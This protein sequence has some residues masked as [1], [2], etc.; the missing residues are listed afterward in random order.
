MN[1][2]E[3]YIAPKDSIF[4]E[5]KEKSIEIWKTYSDEFGYSSSKINR[6]KDVLNIRDN[7]AFIVAMFDPNNQGKLRRLVNVETREWLDK[8]LSYVYKTGFGESDEETDQ[9]TT[10]S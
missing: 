3:Y 9:T 1:E 5:I 7:A 4:Q 2:K 8:L 10:T 6:I